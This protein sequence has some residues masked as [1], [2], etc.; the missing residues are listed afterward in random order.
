MSSHKLPFGLVFKEAAVIPL[1]LI[2]RL[3]LLR[4]VLV[5]CHRAQAHRYSAESPKGN[6]GVGSSSASYCGS[7]WTVLTLAPSLTSLRAD[8]RTL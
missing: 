3:L 1:F 8:P 2:H 7:G 4:Y 6:C 5:V